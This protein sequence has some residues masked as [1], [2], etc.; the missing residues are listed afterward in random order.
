MKPA[1]KTVKEA[2]KIAEKDPDALIRVKNSA[3]WEDEIEARFLKPVIKSP[4]E[5][6]TILVRIEDLNYL[7]FMCHEPKG[8]LAGTKALD[9]LKWGEKQ[10][11]QNRPTCRGRERWWDL[12]EQLRNSYL[13]SRIYNDSHR[14]Y[15]CNVYAAD[16][17]SVLYPKFEFYI[18]GAIL[19]STLSWFG[20]ELYGRKVL[21]EGGLSSLGIDLINIETLK[22]GLAP[23][24]LLENFGK[25]KLREINSIFTELG[26]DPNKPIREQE[27]NPLPDRKAFDDIVFD[28]LGLTEDV[29]NEVYWAVCELVKNRLEKARS[30]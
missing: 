29:R 25:L 9:Y 4:R 18:T 21:G 17:F 8:K 6:K 12:G 24:H 11:Y 16:T 20:K 26:F 1:G 5:L 28:I 19:N 7:V 10:G 30:V 27:P 14:I 3:G 15:E 2:T 23:K 13:W 22:P